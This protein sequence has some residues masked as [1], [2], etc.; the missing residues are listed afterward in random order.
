MVAAL[1]CREIG[2]YNRFVVSHRPELVESDDRLKDYFVRRSIWHREAKYH[3]YKTELANTASLRSARRAGAFCAQASAAFDL[4]ES[5]GSLSQFVAVQPVAVG[6]RYHACG[7]PR[8]PTLAEY[9]PS[10]HRGQFR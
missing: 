6:R 9:A 7:G 3:L 2:R 1:T 5:S 8:L 4:A 10:R